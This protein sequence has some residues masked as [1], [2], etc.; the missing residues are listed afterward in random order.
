MFL[1]YLEALAR[2]LSKMWQ[3]TVFHLKEIWTLRYTNLTY[4]NKKEYG[5]F[6]RHRT[7]DLQES[8][9]I[10]WLVYWNRS[11]VHYRRIIIFFWLHVW[12]SIQLRTL[13]HRRWAY[14]ERGPVMLGNVHTYNREISC[15]RRTEEI[16]KARRNWEILLPF[17]WPAQ[18]RKLTLNSPKSLHFLGCP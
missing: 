7:K 13:P 12:I 15:L 18:K 3:I 10:F 6:L 1:R 17:E 9:P 4:W 14:H 11:S 8:V 16:A 2:S 5:F